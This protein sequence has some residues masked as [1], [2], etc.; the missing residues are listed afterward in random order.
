MFAG[1]W[2]VKS[3]VIFGFEFYSWNFCRD[4]LNSFIPWCDSCANF[5]GLKALE[6]PETPPNPQLEEACKDS[7]V[8]FPIFFA[9]V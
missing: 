8:F 4:R 3:D 2:L 9:K 7:H 5:A 6:I 1:G